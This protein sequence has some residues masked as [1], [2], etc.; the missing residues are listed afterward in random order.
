MYCGVREEE[1]ARFRK[2][3]EKKRKKTHRGQK[4][5]GGIKEYLKT[6]NRVKYFLRTCAVFD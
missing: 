1:R 6:Y 2:K 3:K 5:V 4:W